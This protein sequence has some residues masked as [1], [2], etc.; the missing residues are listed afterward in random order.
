[1]G[2]LAFHPARQLWGIA[3]Q[4]L[5]Q[6]VI[7]ADHHG[8]PIAGLF[9]HTGLGHHLEHPAEQPTML[10]FDP[11]LLAQIIGVHRFACGTH[12]PQAVQSQTGVRP[13]QALEVG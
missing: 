1:M 2:V 4:L 9:E 5:R 8:K 13:C 10:R 11:Q 3:R 7:R 6:G 12:P